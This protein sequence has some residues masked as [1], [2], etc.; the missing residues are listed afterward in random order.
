MRHL[1]R[2]GIL[3]V[4]GTLLTAISCIPMLA[5]LPGG[6]LSGLALLGITAASAPIAALG[7]SLALVAQPLLLVSVGLIIAGHL[8]C[9]RSPVLLA[10]GGGLLLYLAMY[11][12]VSPAPAMEHMTM[13]TMPGMPSATA[14][15][16]GYTSMDGMTGDTTRMATLE[17]MP[18]T[19][20]LTNESLFYAGLAMLL[21]SF[22][23]SWWRQ[24]RNV[25]Q[26]LH[27]L[28]TLRAA[29]DHRA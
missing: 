2:Y 26:P 15:A 16:G 10:A 3:K 6:V 9:G 24:R 14:V 1:S 29:L 25:C 18:D 27:P 11:V 22:G 23:L 5:M 21:G 28:R 19:P 20:G 13:D 8:R 12:F 7:A 17:Q 4:I